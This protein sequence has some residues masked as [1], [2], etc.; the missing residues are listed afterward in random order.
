MRTRNGLKIPVL[1]FNHKPINYAIL[2]PVLLITIT[3]FLSYYSHYVYPLPQEIITI[4][5][6][7]TTILVT[8]IAAGLLSKFVVY[9]ISKNKNNTIEPEQKILS[10]KLYVALIYLIAV[11][12]IFW[13][14]GVTLQNIALFLTLFATGLAFAIR[15]VIISYLA[16]Y[17]LLTKK[18]FRIG[19][20]IRIDEHEGRVEYIGTFYVI[21]D[22][23]P[24]TYDDFVRIPNKLF[25]EKPIKV[26]G[27]HNYEGIIEY[28]LIKIPKD[29]DKRKEKAQKRILEETGNSHQIHLHSNKEKHYISIKYTSKY[30][31]K[32]NVRDKIT[33]IISQEYS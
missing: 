20:H 26:Y 19:D 14:V 32:N 21:I 1:T 2:L 31:E 15:D 33:I 8:L 5:R 17:I 30:G 7:A 28:P 3:I 24:E 13:Q 4:S 10:S 11:M 18:P 22:E 9:R 12:I 16:W 29:Y 25:L 23:Y 6:Q 27:K